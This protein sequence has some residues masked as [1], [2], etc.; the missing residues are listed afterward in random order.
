LTA[1]TA[2]LDRANLWYSAVPSA[3]PVLDSFDFRAESRRRLLRYAYECAQTGRLWTAFRRSGSD[4]GT[5]R[6]MAETQSLPCPA[7]DPF[8]AYVATR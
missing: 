4:G 6:Q 3:Y 1:A 7:D 8:I 2:E 5:S